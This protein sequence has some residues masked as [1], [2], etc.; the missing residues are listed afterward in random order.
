MAEPQYKLEGIVR[1]RSEQMEL[2]ALWMSFSC[3]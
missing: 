2:K 1:S 3:C